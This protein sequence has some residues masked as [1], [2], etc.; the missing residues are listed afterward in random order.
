MW[1]I[2]EHFAQFIFAVMMS[3]QG[4]VVQVQPIDKLEAI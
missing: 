2:I 1:K 4:K 3:K